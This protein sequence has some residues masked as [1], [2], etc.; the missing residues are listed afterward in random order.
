MVSCPN[1]GKVFRHISNLSDV[2]QLGLALKGAC[3]G[4]GARVGVN[5]L[6]R[7]ARPKT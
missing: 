3:P 4:C 5:K 7:A 6:W 1:C 2:R